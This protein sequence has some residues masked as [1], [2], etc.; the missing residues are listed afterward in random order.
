[1]VDCCCGYCYYCCWLLVAGVVEATSVLANAAAVVVAIA[2]PVAVAVAV[3]AAVTVAVAA[4][5]AVAAAVAA[6]GVLVR[7]AV[8]HARDYYF[9]CYC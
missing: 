8:V 2:V 6:A 7:V 5:T 3:P 9:C 4:A 1:M